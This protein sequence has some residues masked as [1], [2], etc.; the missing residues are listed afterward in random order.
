MCNLMGDIRNELAPLN[1]TYVHS[2]WLIKIQKSSSNVHLHSCNY[3]IIEFFE[4]KKKI[5]R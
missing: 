4:E 1:A 2:G 5:I 3:V